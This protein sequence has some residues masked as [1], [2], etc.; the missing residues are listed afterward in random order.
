MR[1]CPQERRASHRNR[2]EE[3]P[4]RQY[5]RLPRI[6]EEIREEYSQLFHRRSG[7]TSS[8]GFLQAEH[9]FT[10]QDIIEVVTY[11]NYSKKRSSDH[12]SGLP[13]EIE[14]HVITTLLSAD[15][16]ASPGAAVPPS[17]RSSIRSYRYIS[18]KNSDINIHRRCNSIKAQRRNIAQRYF[19][20]TNLYRYLTEN[21][22]LESAVQNSEK[23]CQLCKE[24][25]E[26]LKA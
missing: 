20:R 8:G 10:V 23:L 3:R 4:R 1:L 25:P 24:T 13:W 22:D 21:G 19:I 6:H 26:D 11:I 5:R 2:S 7:G 17:T 18:V 16:Q 12:Q 14:V 15:R 9:S